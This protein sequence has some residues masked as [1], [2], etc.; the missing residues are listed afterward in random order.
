MQ[1]KPGP[2]R[3]QARER[4]G[5][6]GWLTW[7]QGAVERNGLRATAR[8]LGVSPATVHRVIRGEYPAEPHKVRH[9]VEQRMGGSNELENASE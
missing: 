6:P 7:L 4:A 9:A 1:S 2:G 3:P 8:T 5:Q